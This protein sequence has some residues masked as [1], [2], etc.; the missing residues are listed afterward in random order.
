VTRKG[1]AITLSVNDR[2]KAK[3]EQ[4]A[5]EFGMTW[6]DKGIEGSE[7]FRGLDCFGH[8]KAEN[9]ISI[10][11]KVSV[12]FIRNLLDHIYSDCHYELK[13]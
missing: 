8:P 10:I 5:L 4:L 7:M 12:H 13:Q 2:Q 11:V 3:L 9:G 1:R 6:G